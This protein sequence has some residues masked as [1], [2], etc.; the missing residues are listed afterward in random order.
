MKTFG[1]KEGDAYFCR[2]Y[3]CDCFADDKNTA[4]SIVADSWYASGVCTETT[5]GCRCGDA[6]TCCWCQCDQ[7]R[8]KLHDR[9]LG[10]FQRVRQL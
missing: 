8:W 10:I 3:R 5:S 7:Q 2:R 6:D 4:F 1:G 9:F